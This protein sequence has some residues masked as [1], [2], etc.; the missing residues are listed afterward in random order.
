[1]FTVRER[2]IFQ[3][4]KSPMFLYLARNEPERGGGALT[5]GN[6]SLCREGRRAVGKPPAQGT[7][8][9]G[10]GEGTWK[11]GARDSREEN[12]PRELR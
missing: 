3:K 4:K 6:G 5:A 8:G 7:E 9:M 1:M 11:S 10:A 12:R 2:E